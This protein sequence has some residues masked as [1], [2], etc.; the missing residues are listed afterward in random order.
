M[1]GRRYDY[2]LI[3]A[4]SVQ[5]CGPCRLT[6]PC[7]QHNHCVLVEFRGPI[8]KA[9]DPRNATPQPTHVQFH[10]LRKRRAP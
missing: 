2:E 9:R 5:T 4:P 6:E 7:H 8:H 1:P 3:L 10:N